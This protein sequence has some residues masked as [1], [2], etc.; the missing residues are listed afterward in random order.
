MITHY[1]YIDGSGEYFIVV[2][3]DKCVG[4][5]KCI[6]ACPMGLEPHL[7]MT[8]AEFEAWDQLEKALIMDCIECG[9]CTFSCPSNRPL[10]DYL[11]IGKSTVGRLRKARQ[12]A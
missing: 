11:R 12:Q 2:D 4:C 9:C 1:G 7:F 10:L 3:S 5:G 6:T 8:L